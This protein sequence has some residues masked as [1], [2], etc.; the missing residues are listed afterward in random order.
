MS[1]SSRKLRSKIRQYPFN[2][3]MAIVAIIGGYVFLLL[4]DYGSGHSHIT[5][6]P[7]KLITSIPCPGCGMG[8]AT[9]AILNGD[10]VKSLYYN[11]LCVPFIIMMFL[12]IG[13]LIYD[14]IIGRDTLFKVI[15]HPLQNKYKIVLFCI[16]AITWLL[17]IYHGI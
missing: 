13:W 9:L 10:F 4:M 8:R 2:T 6:C 16:L 3:I 11:I 15:S 5:T 7:V 12:A 1:E 14:L 17:N